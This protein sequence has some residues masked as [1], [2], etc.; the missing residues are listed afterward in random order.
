MSCGGDGRADSRGPFRRL[1]V[2]TFYLGQLLIYIEVHTFHLGQLLIHIV[3]LR[4]HFLFGPVAHLYMELLAGLAVGWSWCR[5]SGAACGCCSWSW[6]S[7]WWFAERV[8]VA[9]VAKGS[10]GLYARPTEYRGARVLARFRRPASGL[11][12][13]GRTNGMFSPVRRGVP[14]LRPPRSFPHRA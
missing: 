5:G 12:P 1:F 6:A 2:Y 9:S 8:R 10:V 3:A 7:F 14:S 13:P 4:L 11:V